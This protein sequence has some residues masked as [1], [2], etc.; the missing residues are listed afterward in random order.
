MLERFIQSINSSTLRELTFELIWDR[1]V[2][3]DIASVMDIPAWEAVDDALCTVARRIQEEDPERKLNILLSVVAPQPTDLGKV[4]LGALFTKFRE[5]GNVTLKYFVD[6]LP[7]V[8]SSASL[9]KIATHYTFRRVYTPRTCLCWRWGDETKLKSTTPF[10]KK[11]FYP[12]APSCLSFST[13]VSRLE[14]WFTC[15]LL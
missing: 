11:W 10:F 15:H 3:D 13:V 1:Y 7:P 2:N 6:Y 8:S 14:M 9:Y 12:V 5:E 4:K